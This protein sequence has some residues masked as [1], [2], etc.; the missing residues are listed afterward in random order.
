[1]DRIIEVKVNGSYIT[2]DN[3]NAGVQHEANSTSLRIEFDPIWDSYAK[4][5]TWWNA[6]GEDPVEITLGSNLLE[7]AAASTRIYLCPIP[8]EPLA[9][10]GECTFVID[11]YTDGKRQRSAADRLWVKEAPFKETAGQPSDPTPSQAEQLQKEIDEIAA[12]ARNAALLPE[13]GAGMKY[14][15]RNDDKVLETSTDGKSWEATGSSGHVI[16]DAAGNV[17][18]QRS[19]MQFA[20]GT[21]EDKDG[22]TVVHGAKGDKGE[23]G[24]KGDQGPKGETGEQGPQGK[25]GP[26]I[27]PSVDIYGVMSFSIQDNG[28]APQS[29]SVRGPQGP[30]GVQGAQGAQGERG[31]QGIQG[32]QGIQGPKGDKGD[33]GAT[34]PAGAQGIQGVQ[35]IQGK[36]G[37]TGP[38]GPTGATG[39]TGPAGAAGAKGDKGPKGDPFTY[40]DFTQ[41]QLEALKGP[42]GDTGAQG[43]KGDTG[44]QGI[45]GIQGAAGPKGATG[46]QG[47]QGPQGERGN[48]GADGR[49][50][51]IQD[52]YPT[53]GALKA[54]YP[55]GNEYAYQ[56]IAEND[57][58]FIWS[59]LED[60]WASL[61]RLQGPQGP[62]GIQG[63]QG[64]K[65]DQGSQGVQGIQGVQGE[66]GPQG[67]AATIEVGT[68]TTGAAGTSAAVTNAGTK[69][70]AKFNFTI[71]Q[72]AKGEKGDQGEQGPTG[73]T[74]PQGPK[75]ETGDTG[76]AGSQGIQGIQGVQGVQGEKGDKGDTG[77]QG[78]QG[79][80]GEQGEPGPQGPQGPAGTQGADGKSAFQTAVEAGYTGTESAFN[81]ALKEVPGHLANTTV[82]IT[83]AERTKWNAKEEGGAAAA[84]QQ[85]LTAHIGDTVKHVTAAERTAWNGKADLVNGKVP[86]SQLPA[87][88]AFTK[89]ETLKAA[90]AALFGLGASAVPDEVFAELGKYKQ[91]WWRRRTRTEH[92]TWS[93]EKNS[94]EYGKERALYVANGSSVENTYLVANSV[95]VDQSTGEVSLVDPVEDTATYNVGFITSILGKYFINTSAELLALGT[96]YPV[97]SPNQIYF[98]ASDASLS[99]RQSSG[100]YY[101][102]ARSSSK[103][104]VVSSTSTITSITYGDWEY[105]HS[106]S[107]S[108][109]PDSG[110]SGGYEYEYLGIP[111]DNA[112]TA[113]KI[114]TGSYVGTGTYGASNPNTLTFGFVPKLVFIFGSL[115]GSS[116]SSGL[117]YV[118]VLSAT[119]VSG[120]YFKDGLGLSNVNSQAY[121]KMDGTVMSWYY[122]QGAYPDNQFNY[123][124]ATYQYIAIG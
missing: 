42:K 116:Q 4:K 98:I 45:Q 27:V 50:F 59:E 32:A 47:P 110:T 55:N 90:T 82:H 18:P 30:Q 34:G 122:G 5:I 67:E 118:P 33:T 104:Y 38:A 64:E 72:G 105:V 106:S 13:S 8:G 119:Y 20:N 97:V 101:I 107:R 87:A 28:Q 52:I 1:M 21:V 46:A 85:N 77:P 68:V 81:E 94:W 96:A 9:E 88:D 62:Q 69:Y 92:K 117:F 89:A 120:A 43:P 115:G 121:A 51:I 54:D 57:E 111:F 58:I 6:K 99:N 25:T 39:A 79:P 26:V 76:P 112:V 10:C 74:G 108:A 113:P 91:Y 95:S 93:I 35:G 71:P 80:Q 75:G 16:V 12:A 102:N 22:V 109:Y 40:A 78:P 84:V 103:M 3:R 53:L 60:D 14:I 124:T 29:V 70:A 66:Q 73:A 36:Q 11:G 56:V 49:S 65:G 37:A 83:T 41:E 44:A 31:P 123:K 7:D 17:M 15:R 114:E 86:S 19:R 63:V 24:D 61:G 100:V 23:K 48:D 2:K